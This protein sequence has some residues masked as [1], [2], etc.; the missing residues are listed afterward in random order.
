MKTEIFDEITHQGR[1]VQVTWRGQ[2]FVPPRELVTQVSGICFNEDG[3]I[4]LVSKD[5]DSWQLVGGHPEAGETLEE[6]FIREVSDEAC[7]EVLAMRFLRSQEVIDPGN[8]E[9]QVIYYQVR[10]WAKIRLGKFI[11]K[12]EVTEI[13]YCQPTEVKARLNWQTEK[14][15]DELLR[16]VGVVA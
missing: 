9:G 1:Q 6:T 16:V 14:V 10:Y 4:I 12:F 2:P 13:C 5:G 8:P 3:K 11:P 7:A 15:L